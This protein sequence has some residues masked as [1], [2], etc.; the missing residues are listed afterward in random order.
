[1]GA[2]EVGMLRALLERDIR[3][4]ILIGTSIGAWN[5][6]WVATHPHATDVTPLVALWKSASLRL[7]L[8]GNTLSFVPRLLQRQNYLL[9]NAAIRRMLG[10]IFPERDLEDL[11]FADLAIPLRVN[12]TDIMAGAL[13]TFDSGLLLPAMLATCAIPGVFPPIMID[14]QQYVDGGILDNGGVSVAMA[15]GARRI[16]VM[17][18]AY[19][20][21]L[22]QPISTVRGLLDRSFHLI[23]SRHVRQAIERYEGQA[24]FI[25]IED[26]RINEGSFM[27][28]RQTERLIEAG[29]EAAVRALDEHAQLGR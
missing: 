24:E 2:A 4:D 7:F 8:R 18:V 11:T 16:Y 1:M 6:L 26:E 27:G 20:G 15:T 14:G 29:Y 3:P 10:Q 5:A 28:L 12:A 9:S 21:V 22:T 19:G 23:A 13:R 17:S 25:V